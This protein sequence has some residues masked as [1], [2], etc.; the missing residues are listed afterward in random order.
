MLHYTYIATLVP[1]NYCGCALWCLFKVRFGSVWKQSWPATETERLR[2]L[3]RVKG[4]ICDNIYKGFLILMSRVCYRTY[5]LTH[6][7]VQ[8]PS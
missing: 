3:K 5:L 8:S 4:A 6:S 7:M 1:P 2:T